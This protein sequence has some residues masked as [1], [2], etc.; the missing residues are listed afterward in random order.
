MVKWQSRAGLKVWLGIP[1]DEIWT[2]LF[3]ERFTAWHANLVCE[4]QASR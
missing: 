1:I 4:V 3:C 2:A